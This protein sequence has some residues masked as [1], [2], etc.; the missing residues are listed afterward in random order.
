MS[1]VHDAV[2]L[3]GGQGT[4]LGGVLKPAL[5]YGGRTLVERALDAVPGARAVA[6]VTHSPFRFDDR[7]VVVVGEEPPRTGPVAAIAAGLAALEADAAPVTVLLAAD[8]VDP[9]AG[10]SRLLAAVDG[11]RR[12]GAAADGVIAV[13]PAGARQP[14]LAAYRS[15]ALRGAFAAASLPQANAGARGAS[16]RSV[17][18]GMRLDEVPLSWSACADI[19]TPADAA[20][21]GIQIT[22]TARAHDRVA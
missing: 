2:V 13:D 14:L 3:A 1:V 21:H 20:R 8:L 12:R 22:A 18:E 17:L 15:S 4:R 9:S 10:V 19:D 16:V 5:R 7:R 11:R 6:V